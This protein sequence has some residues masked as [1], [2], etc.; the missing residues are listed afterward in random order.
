MRSSTRPS[1]QPTRSRDG[2]RLRLGA[3][4]LGRGLSR[5]HRRSGRAY[6]ALPGHRRAAR[7]RAWPNASTII[8]ARASRSRPGSRWRS[9]GS[10]DGGRRA[11]LACRRPDDA[12]LAARGRARRIARA[13]AA[14][15]R[16]EEESASPVEEERREVLEEGW[17][18]AMILMGSATTAELL[19][20]AL[21]ARG[22]ALPPVP[23]GRRAGLSASAP[24]APAAAARGSASRPCCAR[25]RT[26][27]SRT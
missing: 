20:P 17:R 13:V 6:R 24:C 3:A 18:R 9:A 15:A 1:L 14:P 4:A 10:V 11:P 26:P 21:G 8:S 19:D 25:S 22:S 5:L 2:H 7:A 16:A 12:A 23:R 27:S